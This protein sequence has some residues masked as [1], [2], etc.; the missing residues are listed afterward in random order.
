[1]PES[2]CIASFPTQQVAFEGVETLMQTLLDT[3]KVLRS[4]LA[5]LNVASNARPTVA[6]KSTNQVTFAMLLGEKDV[7]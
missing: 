3:G 6:V 2:I 5:S 4:Q 7:I 1:M